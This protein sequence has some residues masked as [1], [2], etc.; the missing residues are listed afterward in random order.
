MTVNHL[1]GGLVDDNLL[2]PTDRVQCAFNCTILSGRMSTP[3]QGI[4]YELI[5]IN[6]GVAY[7]AAAPGRAA[8]RFF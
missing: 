3:V 4:G 1:A 5:R 7:D 6:F 8:R 2:H